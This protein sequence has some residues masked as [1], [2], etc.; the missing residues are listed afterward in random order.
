M[1]NNTEVT[2][3]QRQG[4]VVKN[5]GFIRCSNNLTIVQRKSFAIMLKETIDTIREEGEKRYYEMRLVDY[6]RIMNYHESMPTKYIAEELK[7][8]MTKVVEWDIDK[9]GYGTRS[10]LLA[11]FE[12]QNTVLKWAFSP[13]LIDKLLKDGYTPLKLSIVLNFNSKYSLAL[14]ENIQMRKSFNKYTFNLQEF[15]AL[16]GVEEGEYLQMTHLKNRVIHPAIEEINAKS[17][18]K[19]VYEDVKEGAKI[20]G[21]VLKWETLT[22]E[23]MKQRNK[24]KEQIEG[25]QKALA[26]NFGMKFKIAGKWY[27]LTKQ[28]FVN[29]G[30]V[31][32]GVDIVDSYEAY[33]KLEQQGL[34]T[35][36]KDKAQ[37]VTV[38]KTGTKPK[39][40]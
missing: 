36:K 11:G 33:K 32:G 17:D 1:P 39:S 4:E 13:F 40:T 5:N 20:V 8:L 19:L 21:F 7:E 9:N 3:H 23:Q 18:L 28:G 38:K 15:R 34:V 10:V 27:T 31:L 6:R 22:L 14:Y 35:E 16:M 37:S 24:R 30:K 12:V 2:I 25:Y 29:C 26:S